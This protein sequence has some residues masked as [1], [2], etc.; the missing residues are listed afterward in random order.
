VRA[1]VRQE[2]F[3]G[4]AG[5]VQKVGRDEV[6]AAVDRIRPII[7]AG[8]VE[9]EALRTLPRS[10]VD[11]LRSER[12]FGFASPAELGGF[13]LDPK[14]QFELVEE[15]TRLDTSAGW[16]LYVGGTTTAMAL[17]YLGDRAVARICGQD[18]QP[19]LAGHHAPCGR[20]ERA[21]GG[22]RV[23]GRWGWGSGI[24]HAGW[25]LASAMVTENGT[26]VMSA[27]GTPH[28]ITVVVP[29]GAVSIEDTW[30]VAGLQGTGSEHYSM[31]DLFVEEDFA[32]PYPAPPARRGGPLFGLSV[33][34][35][36]APGM[37][38]FAHGAARRALEEI[39]R[40]APRR[41]AIWTSA[42]IANQGTFQRE[43]GL[44]RV[45]LAAA[46]LLGLEKVDALWRAQIAGRAPSTDECAMLCALLTYTYDVASEIV[47]MALRHAGANVL[48]RSHPLQ[49]VFRDLQAAAQ[50]IVISPDAYESAGRAFLG[51]A[52]PHPI[53]AQRPGSPS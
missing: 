5:S 1:G 6:L 42:C 28:S 40:I 9:A 52:E 46:R 50:H 38:A 48:Y 22:Y 33:V 13:E 39:A 24:R 29:A 18:S 32:L 7:E 35:F 16:T 53:F 17:G 43:I 8:A 23:S 26:P 30:H 37:L 19:I 4:E 25:V 14:M 21:P 20:A 10:V 51:I 44:A 36:V 15:V 2:D 47:T 45:K 11:A 12:L 41:T 49:R 34:A 31:Q 27:G 3:V